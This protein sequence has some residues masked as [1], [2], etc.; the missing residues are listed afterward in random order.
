MGAKIL[1]P[2][3]FPKEVTEAVRYH[4]EDYGG[5]GYP[6]GISGEEI[7]VLARIIRVADAYDAMTS[8]RPYRKAYP[9][10]WVVRELQ[11]CAGRQ[12]DPDVVQAFLVVVGKGRQSEELFGTAPDQDSPRRAV[13]DYLE[14]G[15][16]LSK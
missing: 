3:K 14:S 7:P 8:D 9:H 15:K 5:G 6:E 2:A 13:L 1:E 4:H 11:R 10:E 16:K 12:F